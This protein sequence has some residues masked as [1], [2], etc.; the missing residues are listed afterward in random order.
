MTMAE[1]KH[2]PGP[3]SVRVNER[4]PYDIET[5]S[6]AG[7]VVFSERM[8]A[9]STKMRSHDDLWAGVGF[10][11]NEREE[12]VETNRRAVA[13]ATI[14][15]A[16]PDLFEAAAE[17]CRRVEAGEIRSKRSYAAFKA[18]LSKATA[19]QEGR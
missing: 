10:P 19:Q 6:A 14:R 4:W 7:E 8:P 15:A 11:P 13:D 5:L 3:L 16:A 2:T 9:H 12:I 1:V 18:A 17:F